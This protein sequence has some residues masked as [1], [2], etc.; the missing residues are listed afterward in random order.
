MAETKEKFYFELRHVMDRFEHAAILTTLMDRMRS[1]G[2]W[3]GETH[4]QKGTY[5]LQD[6]LNVNL[7]FSFILYRHGP[8]SFDL[9]DALSTMRS[10]QFIDVDIQPYPYGPRLIP[11]E[12]G[13]LFA[14]Q[15]DELL[16]VYQPRIEF[17]ATR[18]SDK[19]V[20]DLER[21]ATAFYVS[22]LA[23]ATDRERAEQVHQLKPHVSI[24]EA[25]SAVRFVDEFSEGAKRFTSADRGRSNL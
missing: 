11:T 3:C 13:R 8:F 21:Y 24:P 17:V 5:F 2:S 7:D 18:L 25:L 23:S 10:D 20:A 12:L 4:I 22:R 15:H 6:L 19:K 14:S 16:R 1:N 9:R